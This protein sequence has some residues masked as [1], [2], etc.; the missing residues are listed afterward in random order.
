MEIKAKR[1][2]LLA[3]LYWMQSIV[4]R[5]NTMPILA[6]VLIESQKN[7]IRLTATDLEVGVRGYVEGEVVKEGTVTINAKKLYEIVREVPT[8]QVQLKRLENDWVE[9]KSGKSVFKIVGMEAREFPQFPKF[10]SKGLSTTPASTI[11]QMI[12]RTIFSVSTDETRYSLN[13]VFIEEG[14][15]G[16]VRM[17]STDGHRLAFEERALG[18]LGLTKGVILPRKGLAEL[19]KLLDSGEEE[20]VSIGFRENMGL[21]VKNKVELFMRLIDGDFPDYT[22]VIPKGNPNVA[23]IEHNE[24]LQ[25]LRRVSILS[26]ERYKGIRMDFSDGSVSISANNPDLGE[27]MEEIDAEYNGKPVSIGFNARYLLDVLGVLN[28]E[29][30]IEIELKDELSPS[31]IRKRG[32]EGYLYVLMPMRL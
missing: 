12:E 14:D 18:S 2:D 19:K 8:D 27:A 6:N 32:Q 17:V 16:K 25:A 31:V 29:G 28:G 1:G 22:K 15:G 21:V 30:E 13:G 24:L 5:R 3:T 26:S 4:E 20:V 23:R 9:I 10:D 11:R 7:E